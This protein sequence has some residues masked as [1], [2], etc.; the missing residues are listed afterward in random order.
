M[1]HLPCQAGA[2]TQASM[3]EQAPFFRIYKVQYSRGEKKVMSS[4]LDVHIIC[5]NI[6]DFD[7]TLRFS[8]HYENLMETLPNRYMQILRF[9]QICM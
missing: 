9:L 6:Y 2:I 7:L 8:G 5:F 3:M 4:S 1:E